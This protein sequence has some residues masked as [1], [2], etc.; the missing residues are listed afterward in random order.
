MYI[1][2]T[3]RVRTTYKTYCN[4]CKTG[5]FME[6]SWG[7]GRKTF[8]SLLIKFQKIIH[9]GYAVDL[10]HKRS[11]VYIQFFTPR[12][13]NTMYFI[14]TGNKDCALFVPQHLLGHF[15]LNCWD[16]ALFTSMC[17]WTHSLP[18]L[19][20]RVATFGGALSPPTDDGWNLWGQL[21]DETWHIPPA[22]TYVLENNKIQRKLEDN[23]KKRFLMVLLVVK[24]STGS[25]MR[26][27]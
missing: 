27:Y 23:N 26:K 17:T 16:P 11:S 7:G 9:E 21:Q 24:Y 12:R 3:E 15:F 20:C 8:C 5:E 4:V 10:S 6:D 1:L 14:L 18:F 22:G 2:K 25:L 13:K 19:L